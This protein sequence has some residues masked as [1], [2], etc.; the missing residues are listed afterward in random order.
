MAWFNKKEEKMLP[1]LPVQEGLPKLPELSPDYMQNK[2]QG[3]P[4]V[5]DSTG[6]FN[7]QAIK[8]EIHGNSCKFMKFM[9]IHDGDIIYES[10]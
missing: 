4:S 1:D 3:L 7:R 9:K 5:P 2:P 8:N 10:S 6:N